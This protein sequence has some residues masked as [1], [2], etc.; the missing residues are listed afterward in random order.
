[1]VMMLLLLNSDSCILHTL[2]MAVLL[3]NTAAI[4]YNEVHHKIALIL[5]LSYNLRQLP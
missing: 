2:F 3:T 1:M 4:G 5:D